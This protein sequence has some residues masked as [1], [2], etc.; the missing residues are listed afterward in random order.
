MLRLGSLNLDG[1]R[2]LVAV[3]FTDQDDSEDLAAAKA[4]GV[5]IAELRIDLFER[6]NADYV[7][8]QAR[9]LRGLPTIATIRLEAEG[10][11]W[12]GPESQRAE[13]FAAVLPY[14]DAI[15]V[16]LRARQ[17]IEALIPA[18][19]EQDKVLILSHHDLAGTPSYEAL[20]D[21]CREAL[22]TGANIVKIATM[23]RDDDD[24]AVLS[25]LLKERPAPN[26]VVIGMGEKGLPSRVA[27]PAKG[28]LFTFAAL[29]KRASAPGQLPYETM[30]ELLAQAK[31]GERPS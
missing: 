13:I 15:D 12:T 6:H 30:F 8:V 17:T 1:T 9:R 10:G 21:I 14:V 24:L 19:Q 2:P 28:S 23:V 26:L 4:A 5:A 29:G 7:Q 16:E 11:R 25:R 3:S 18:V 20:S 27:F 31:I 22:K